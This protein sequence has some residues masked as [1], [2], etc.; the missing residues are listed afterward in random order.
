MSV[1]QFKTFKTEC[2]D[3]LVELLEEALKEAKA[4]K[5]SSGALILV[6]PVGSVAC[7][8]SLSDN[9]H[10]LIAGCHYL[11]HDIMEGNVGEPE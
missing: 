2:V 4:G 7:R 5:F 9:T 11:S 10:A 6:R 1:V 8:Y 3:D